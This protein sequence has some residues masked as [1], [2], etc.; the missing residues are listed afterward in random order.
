MELLRSPNPTSTPFWLWEGW[1][2]FRTGRKTKPN[3][4]QVVLQVTQEGREEGTSG[5][6]SGG[7]EAL[8]ALPFQAA[9][10]S[11]PGGCGPFLP[12]EEAPGLQARGPPAR[13]SCQPDDRT[14]VS[15]E[16]PG[17]P[18][19]PRPGAQSPV[20][21]KARVGALPARPGAPSP[22]GPHHRASKPTRLLLRRARTA[23]ATVTWCGR[24]LRAGGGPRASRAGS[25]EG[26]GRDRGERGWPRLEL[27]GKA[28]EFG[29]SPEPL[30]GGDR[31]QF[32]FPDPV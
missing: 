20:A 30:P 10:T 26:E 1:K 17:L 22:R 3:S 18:P 12:A 25:G 5:R 29:V 6:S 4:M 2:D 13:P 11:S 7:E 21:A 14:Q 8:E 9:S 27:A 16:G 31:R 19:P 15:A 24:G 23:D 32:P 28:G